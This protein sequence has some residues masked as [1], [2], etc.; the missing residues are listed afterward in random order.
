MLNI[1]I[2]YMITNKY[3]ASGSYSTLSLLPAMT[4]ELHPDYKGSFSIHN[5]GQS[6]SSYNG[7]HLDVYFI[8][9]L[10]STEC[11]SMANF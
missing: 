3:I 1:I 6:G 11:K 10:S 4:L 8:P 9:N 5:G 2:S 7:G